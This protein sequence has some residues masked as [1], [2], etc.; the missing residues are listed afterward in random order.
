MILSDMSALGG[1]FHPEKKREYTV[2]EQFYR[3]MTK[4]ENSWTDIIMLKSR[5]HVHLDKMGKSGLPCSAIAS[6]VEF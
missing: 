6:S 4:E 2:A 1:C 3:K 5:L